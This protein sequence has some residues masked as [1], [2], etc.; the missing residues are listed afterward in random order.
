MT[1][2]ENFDLLLTLKR[3]NSRYE[4]EE[5]LIMEEIESTLNDEVKSFYIK[6]SEFYNTILVEL[7]SDP[8]EIALKL[9]NTPI[10]DLS[11]IVPIEEVVITRPD[12]ITEKVINLGREKMN[13]GE[14]FVMK[15]NLRGK[16]Y[17]KSKEELLKTIIP[18]LIKELKVEVDKN[19]ADW[20]IQIE[21]VGENTGITIL[22]PNDLI[23]EN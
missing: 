18:E 17:I 22:R 10:N 16:R 9:Q 8:L 7:E 15:C 2:S 6:E 11:Q 1:P 21:V 12:F 4:D 5:F 13:P 23:K 19:K 20:L 3:Y 14:N